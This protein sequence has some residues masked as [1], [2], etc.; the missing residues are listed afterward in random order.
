MPSRDDAGIREVLRRKKP[1]IPARRRAEKIAIWE[2][3]RD[4]VGHKFWGKAK[5]KGKP[6]EHF[7]FSVITERRMSRRLMYFWVK[8]T[9]RK[10]KYGRKL[11]RKRYYHTY[12]SFWRLHSL[13]WE[14]DFEDVDYDYHHTAT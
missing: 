10:M 11:P 6:W 7:E 4:P 8:E 13:D 14:K 9:I 5:E 1:R 12:P 2:S 3:K